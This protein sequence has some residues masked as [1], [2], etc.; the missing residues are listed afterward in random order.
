M[1]SEER[2]SG[3]TARHAMSELRARIEDLADGDRP[4]GS[5]HSPGMFLHLVR[6][7]N[8]GEFLAPVYSAT[9]EHIVVAARRLQTVSRRGRDPWKEAVLDEFT[10]FPELAVSVAPRSPVVA[11]I[12]SGILPDH[13]LL[14]GRVLEAVDMT[15]EGI[16]DRSGHGT[17]QAI[18]QIWHEPRAR[19]V[20]VKAF[21]GPEQRP[22]MKS[23]ARALDYLAGLPE[24]GFVFIAGG[25]DTNSHS[26]GQLICAM[27]GHLVEAKEL[28]G[29]FVATRG[30]I[31]NEGHWCPGDADEVFGITV[32]DRDTLLP[33][34]GPTGGFAV[35]QKGQ[36]T[37]FPTIEPMRLGPFHLDCARELRDQGL[38]DAAIE[39]AREAAK[40]KILR[41]QAR[42]T[43]G[44]ILIES[45]SP[46]E[47]VET[48]RAALNLA[49][50]DPERVTLLGTLGRALFRAGARDEAAQV[51][52][53]ACSA[54]VRDAE[55]VSDYAE[56]LENAGDYAEALV[57]YVAAADLQPNAM[58]HL[59][60]FAWRRFY[61]DDPLGARPAL[62]WI[63]M[64]DPTHAAARYNIA[65]VDALCGRDKAASEQLTAYETHLANH[66]ATSVELPAPGEGRAAVDTPLGAERRFACQYAMG[67]DRGAHRAFDRVAA[68]NGLRGADWPPIS[69]KPLA[70]SELAA[71]D[72]TVRRLL[73][74]RRHPLHAVV[75]KGLDKA[76]GSGLLAE[77]A[78]KALHDLGWLYLRIG[79]VGNARAAFLRAV[80]S[81][82]DRFTRLRERILVD[83]ARLEAMS[84]SWEKANELIDEMAITAWTIL[85]SAERSFAVP[86]THAVR[87]LIELSRGDRDAAMAEA[88]LFLGLRPY[89]V[90]ASLVFAVAW[91]PADLKAVHTV[92]RDLFSRA[93]SDPATMTQLRRSLEDFPL[94]DTNALP[95][96][97]VSA[98]LRSVEPTLASRDVKCV[99][100]PNDPGSRLY[101]DVARALTTHSPWKRL[102]V[103]G[104]ALD[105]DAPALKDRFPVRVKFAKPDSATTKHASQLLAA[106][107]DNAL[108][109][110]VISARILTSEGGSTRNFGRALLRALD[111][112]ADIVLAPL[113]VDRRDSHLLGLVLYVSKHLTLI[114][115]PVP[116]GIGA[117]FPADVASLVNKAAFP[118]HFPS[119]YAIYDHPADFPSGYVLREWL[120]TPEGALPGQAWAAPTLDDLHQALPAN[121]SRISG[122]DITDPTIAE[123]WM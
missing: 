22:T 54:G 95:G 24:L 39:H 3:M 62:Q 26:Q 1:T 105:T 79:D 97:T 51:L 55:V 46:A 5:L 59:E 71:Y 49:V 89:D 87:A 93:W 60:G 31:G 86:A 74:Q 6:D 56:L 110:Q 81:A 104:G 35:V 27:A 33:G 83:S 80:E 94:Y 36:F 48:T 4:C 12:D 47:A 23:F 75:A 42:I 19:L 58:D 109:S 69:D 116:E 29:C 28:H 114:A 44:R 67:G 108:H 41:T 8:N 57:R 43:E 10:P 70:A 64:K 17:I 14:A 50:E 113:A 16:E 98:V 119:Q 90:E 34:A 40:D 84:G 25:V 115:A 103:I 53:D 92:I 112:G 106:L 100:Y 11:L 7:G 82:K 2:E 101:S 77:D 68:L 118:P 65:M 78:V 91:A 85:P 21:G 88:R 52:A 45:E 96:D 117:S 107:G 32:T 102:V 20:I 66:L 37:S 121:A 18:R 30:N 76:I 123:V 72:V 61:S 13:P 9:T 38:F 63:L 111:S 73:L 15:G 122:Q 99:T 120:L